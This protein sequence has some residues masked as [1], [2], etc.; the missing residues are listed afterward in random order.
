MRIAHHFDIW[1]SWHNFLA[2]ASP[3]ILLNNLCDE[4]WT[5]G[6]LACQLDLRREVSIP[7]EYACV[8]GVNLCSEQ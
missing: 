7:D 1:I 4:A 8:A 2:C 3:P 5:A 6:D